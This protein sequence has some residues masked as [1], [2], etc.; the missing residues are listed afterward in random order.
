MVDTVIL[1]TK[2]FGV[3]PKWIEKGRIYRRKYHR[4]KESHRGMVIISVQPDNQQGNRDRLEIQIT[5]LPK[6]L[7][8][9]NLYGFHTAQE[10]ADAKVRLTSILEEY[11]IVDFDIDEMR[12]KRLDLAHTFLLNKP[13]VRYKQAL[14]D[15]SVRGMAKT[16]FP[17]GVGLTT[18]NRRYAF[19]DKGRQLRKI[20]QKYRTHYA[21]IAQEKLGHLMRAEFQFRSAK[22]VWEK[23]GVNTWWD[24]EQSANL[25]GLHQKFG[26]MIK[27]VFGLNVVEAAAANAAS[28]AQDD[29]GVL[30][31]VLSSAK[32]KRGTR[33]L[34][35]FL[36]DIG[37]LQLEMKYGKD[38]INALTEIIKTRTPSS[39]TEQTQLQRIIRRKKNIPEDYLDLLNLESEKKNGLVLKRALLS[40][41][42][43][44][45]A[46]QKWNIGQRGVDGAEDFDSESDQ[47]K[48]WLERQREAGG[49]P[50]DQERLSDLG[51]YHS[52]STDWRTML[53]ASELDA[54]I[55][56]HPL[57]EDYNAQKAM[58]QEYWAKS[59][60]AENGDFPIIRKVRY[61]D[62]DVQ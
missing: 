43:Q 16:H 38:F 29:M 50:Y 57:V 12:I 37:Y 31:S 51:S 58:A 59:W 25:D 22:E 5:S 35:P 55:K 62:P 54:F 39:K 7:Y 36:S 49:Q 20:S 53:S 42:L 41:L 4:L 44:A 11:G 26:E 19:Y 14:W 21:F 32:T 27:H 45:L 61:D 6:L 18:R 28:S 13:V 3:G 30:R 23:V 33:W 10:Y 8:L 56:L 46:L 60:L 9:T 1:S 17:E 48:E 2:T 15:L 40:E 47:F 34:A 52:F 24:L